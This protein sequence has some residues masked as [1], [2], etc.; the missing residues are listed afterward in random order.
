[1]RIG[2]FDSGVGGITVLREAINILPDADYI[3]YADTEN[4]PYGTKEKEVVKQYIFNAASFMAKKNID[5]LV[6]AC[7]T[8]TSIAVR[9]LR[10]IYDFPIIGME[11]AVKPAV[12]NRGNKKVLVTATEL[13]LKEEKFHNLIDKL[14][15]RDI[16][17]SLPLSKLVEYA[18]NFIFDNE[19]IIKYLDEQLSKYDLE[20][21]GT[22]VLGCTHFP[23]YRECFKKV[24]PS[25][26]DIIDGNIGTVNHMRN[27]LAEKEGINSYGKGSRTFYS[28]GKEDKERLKRYLDILE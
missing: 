13:T 2:I 24:V 19:I 28:S 17:D 9:D 25:H 3:Y 15:S 8:A 16:V 21:Y 22:I 27:L 6:I 4:V 23:F 11:P 5:A 1:M 18:E 12:E 7:N 10:G 26:I 20:E 14:D